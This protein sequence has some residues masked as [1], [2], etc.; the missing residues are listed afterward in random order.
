MSDMIVVDYGSQYTFLLSRRIRELGVKCEVQH[1]N[2][3]KISKNTIGIVLSG[4]PQSV[5]SEKAYQLNQ[6]I[7]DSNL[8][9]LAICYGF[10]LISK[11][12]NGKVEKHDHGE[13][14]LM[15][16]TLD[17][18]DPVLNDIPENIVTW[19]SHGDS[20]TTLPEGFSQIAKSS[21]GIIAGAKKDNIYSFQFHPEV[22][23]TQYGLNIIKNFLFKICKAKENWNLGEYSEE[24]IQN[25][26]KQIG[27]RKVIGGVSG[28]VDSTVAAYILKKAIG[29]NMIGIFV[30]HGLLRKNEENVVPDNLR[31]LGINLIEVDASEIFLQRLRGITEPEEKRKI[32]GE[33]FI[34]VFEKEAKKI[35]SDYL[36]QGTIYSDVIES[37]A[38]S[39]T[40]DKIKSHH[41]VGGLPERMN[42]KLIE[43]LR[44]LFK[45][46]VRELGMK[47]GI[48]REYINRQPFP[49]PGLAIRII[50]T[51]D[52]RKVNILK[53]VDFIYRQT[54]KEFNIYKDIWQSFAVL[55]PVKSVGVKGDM[56]SYGYV[57]ALRA[58]NSAEGMTASW[59]EI[60]YNVL[61]EASSRI[62]GKI[63]EIGRVVY[64]ITDK[65]P[66]TIEWE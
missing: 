50:G 1:P 3:I 42:L 18:T 36:L 8:P 26:K 58:V 19:M 62:T 39:K 20:V 65:P 59:Y 47:M 15:E 13:Y 43:P 23:H 52:E 41:N 53:E 35:D 22:H 44:E 28:G 6:K 40:S 7:I 61:R 51:I 56:R 4:G 34:E 14:G 12:F 31:K 48:P 10:Q 9:I 46:E 60:P 64:D 5:Y 24:L 2:D 21:S 37:A 57:A 25:L 33:T 54:L 66:S 32:I 29:D 63:S 16:V 38:S 49:G 45:D 27:N 55:L 30:N 17:N 11:Y